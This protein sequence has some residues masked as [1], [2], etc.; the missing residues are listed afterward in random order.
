MK[1]RKE[2]VILLL[3]LS[4]FLIAPV[5]VGAGDFVFEKVMDGVI[6]SSTAAKI[7]DLRGF[8]EFAM[9][10]RFEG[11]PGAKVNFEIAFNRITLMSDYVRLNSAGWAN[12]AKIY[13]VYAPEV[14]IVIYNPPPRLKVKIMV[15]AAR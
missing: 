15:Y 12:F 6:S 13:P 9:V 1:K 5:K 3:V 8:K 11:R 14:G 7:V 2:M 10:A 4:L